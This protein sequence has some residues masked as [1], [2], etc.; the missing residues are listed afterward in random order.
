LYSIKKVSEILDIPSV[1]IRAWENRYQ[2]VVPTRTEGGHRVYSESDIE[3]LKWLKKQIQ[4][5]NMKISDAVRL[6]PNRFERETPLSTETLT[7]TGYQEIKEQLYNA[8]IQLNSHEAHRITDLAFSL[9]DF[10]KVLHQILAHVLYEIGDDWEGGIIT[11]AQEHFASEFI[12]QRCSQF[13]R[14]LPIQAN[15]P[16]V[17]AL[18]PDEEHHQIGLTLF[19]LFLRKKGHEVVF[20]GSNTPLSGLED[21]IKLKNIDIVAISITHA[22]STAKVEKWITSCIA[23]FPHLKFVIGGSSTKRLM[24]SQSQSVS[25]PSENQWEGWYQSFICSQRER[26]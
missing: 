1:T 23:T 10:E 7:V 12:M 11:V 8:L 20:L 13:L 3:T 15:L 4:D 25:F 21:L 17:L 22:K 9:F 2:V 19:S 5:K 16:V 6:L 14:N 18:C 26:R 24:L